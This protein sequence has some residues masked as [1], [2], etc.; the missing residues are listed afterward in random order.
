MQGLGDLFHAAASREL[1]AVCH[2]DV[3]ASMLP[4]LFGERFYLSPSLTT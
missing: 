1:H 4:M 2:S 3:N